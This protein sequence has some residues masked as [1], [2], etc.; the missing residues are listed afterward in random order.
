MKAASL[1]VTH[2]NLPASI[3]AYANYGLLLG[4]IQSDYQK[5]YEFADL[6]MQLSYKLDSKSQECKAA[7]LCGAWI[8]VWAKPIAGA[9]ETN[10][11]GFLAGIESGE[12]QFAAYNL[13]GNIFN[14]IFQGE[15]L[16]S[17]AEDV[18][19][20][21]SIA[22]KIKDELLWISLAGAHIFTQKLCLTQIEQASSLSIVASE[23]T[24]QQGKTS[25]TW[26]GVCLYYILKMHLAC[27]IADFE[28]GL[29]Y[30]AAAGKIL[31][32]AIGFTT[33][34]DYYYYGSLILLNGTVELSPDSA[35]YSFSEGS[36]KSAAAQDMVE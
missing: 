16:L 12:I 35:R 24:I 20:Y 13:Y 14:R 31:N 27:L 2:G 19:K 32:S 10:Y 8:H 4:L 33:Y 36:R 26:F 11:Q 18:E 29:Q 28:E 1:S 22:D 25:Q 23:K 6:A 21:G 15:N 7:L 17:I 5:G 9:A 30:E 3:K 34:S